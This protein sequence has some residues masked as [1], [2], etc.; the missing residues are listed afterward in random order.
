MNIGPTALLNSF[1]DVCMIG[2]G[3]LIRPA[4]GLL[5]ILSIITVAWHALMWSFDE[6]G[7]ALKDFIRKIIF[8][9]AFI[10]IIKSFPW[11]VKC[12]ISGFEW[13]GNTAGNQA[14]AS[15]VN[16]PSEI[17]IQGIRVCANLVTEISNSSTITALG[18]LMICF[19]EFLAIILCFLIIAA[20][21]FLVNVELAII[22]TLGVMLIPFGVWKPTAFIAEKLFGAI[23][24]YGVQL[25]VLAFIISVSLPFLR[26]LALPP[27]PS[28]LDFVNTFFGAALLAFLAWHAPRVAAGMI[29]GSPSLSTRDVSSVATRFITTFRRR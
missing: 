18:H 15:I 8:I 16:D 14:N 2:Q 24:S 21:V 26:Q 4:L 6:S 5:A 28:L 23:I 9:G 13:V 19:S 17:M 20:Q 12:V 27:D 22:T 29:S 11:L 10:F 1:L 25:M 3:N 7:N